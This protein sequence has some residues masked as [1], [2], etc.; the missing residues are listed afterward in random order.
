MRWKSWADGL[1]GDKV[2]QVRYRRDEEEEELKPVG[3]QVGMGKRKRGAGRNGRKGAEE[4]VKRAGR[5]EEE[6]WWEVTGVLVGVWE[7][8]LREC[9]E[10][11]PALESM[12][13]EES[14]EEGEE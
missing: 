14:D 2:G 11:E 12:N 5:V 6:S 3:W 4:Q 10:W 9:W 7:R 8:D 13:Q 1:L